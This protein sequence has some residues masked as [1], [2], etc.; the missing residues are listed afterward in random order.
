MA[1][2]YMWMLTFLV[3]DFLYIPLLCLLMISLQ[4]SAGLSNG[5]NMSV[6]YSKTSFLRCIAGFLSASLLFFMYLNLTAT[7]RVQS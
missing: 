2:P 4:D 3:N 6:G 1:P 7:L 5:E